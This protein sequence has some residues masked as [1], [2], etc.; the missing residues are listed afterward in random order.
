MRILTILFLLLS[1]LTALA[2]S[3]NVTLDPGW[4]A[5]AFPC[6][7]LR[8]LEATGVA[9]SVYYDGTSYQTSSLIPSDVQTSR[10]FWVYSPGGG[11]LRFEDGGAASPTSLSARAGWNLVAFPIEG[12]LTGSQLRSPGLLAIYE[13][14]SRGVAT[15]VD[16]LTGRLQPGRAYWV[17][18]ERAGLVEW[19][20][21]S[22]PQ[23]P[24]AAAELYRQA[25]GGQWFSQADALHPD[26]LPTSDGRSFSVVWKPSAAPRQWIAP[27]HG[28]DGFATDDL[29]LWYP[30][31]KGRDI[32]MVC[33]Q[34]WLG[35]AESYYTPTEIY[36]EV[37]P[38]L[39]SLGV[40]PGTAMLHGFSRGS[41]NS[42]ALAAYDAGRGS[43]YFNLC[44]ASS[45][46]VA[47]DY[48]PTRAILD[49][50]Y[51]TRPLQS[52]RWVTAA[53][54]TDENPERDGIPAMRRTAEWLAQQ[55]AVVAD[56][57]EDPLEGH[58]ALMRNPAN[59]QRLLDLF[60]QSAPR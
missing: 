1:P 48:P 41:A 28:S 55:G 23:L 58:G 19:G 46:G 10:G 17:Y 60:V 39:R 32:G 40:Q 59:T 21:Q 31:V 43:R 13:L 4:N 35:A 57:I 14:S 7:A 37:E 5:V 27:L 16:R 20:T 50:T 33:V 54:A 8:S 38:V 34:W 6:S 30:S 24:A 36:R 47:V 45:G 22:T 11:Q 18:A 42:Y 49:G 26:L 25:Q 44:V 53:G 3:G 2:A 15:P 29:A 52:T 51:G 56:A 12:G 9:G